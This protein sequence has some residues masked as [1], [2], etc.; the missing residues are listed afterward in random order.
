MSE[1]AGSDVGAELS[2]DGAVREVLHVLKRKTR[3][4]G[5]TFDR[6]S[7]SLD[8]LDAAARADRASPVAPALLTV[9][10]PRKRSRMP[11]PNT[12]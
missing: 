10:A 2:I 9:R 4:G 5:S 8:A 11:G 1:A 6:A 3:G 12:Q 7:D